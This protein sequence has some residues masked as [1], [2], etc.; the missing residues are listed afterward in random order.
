MLMKGFGTAPNK[1]M[2]L[3]SK[4]GDSSVGKVP[5]MQ[6]R[7]PESH[8][9]HPPLRSQK[10]TVPAPVCTHRPEEKRQIWACWATVLS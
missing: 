6:A 8:H 7:G 2:F 10:Q 5:V 4:L 3:G 9:Q 1:C